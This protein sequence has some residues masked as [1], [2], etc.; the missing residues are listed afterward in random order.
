MSATP[1]ALEL[2]RFQR[3]AYRV[4]ALGCGLLLIGLL[5]DAQQFFRSYLV[6]WLYW[7]APALGSL[8]I[9]MLHKLTGGAWG[10]GIRRLLEAGM[11]TLPL[12]AGLFVPIAFG[13]GSLYEWSHADVVAADP[14]LQHKSVYLNVPFFLA[15]ALGYFAL[16]IWLARTILRL[17]ESYDRNANPRLL[18]RIGRLAGPGLGIYVLTMSFAAFDWGMS[19]E[20]H[21][22]STIY[23]LHFIVGQ[24]LAGLCLAIVVSARL[25][26]REPF[27]RWLGP[28]HF[29][30]LGNLTLAFVMLW[31]YISFSQFLIVWSGNLPE[32][33]PWYIHRLHHGWQAL[34]L[35]LVV[36]HFALPFLVLL[37]RR[38]KR[39]ARLLAR[40]ALVLLALRFVD[41]Y[42]YIAPSFH[43]DGFRLSWMDAAAMVGVGGLWLGTYTR[44]LRGRPLVSLQDARLHASLE[45]VRA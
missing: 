25:S 27:S 23:G 24:A 34:S 3:R 12:L 28:A 22:F 36:F 41:L 20:P 14:L 17:T 43:H 9:V 33:T 44:M 19:L 4:G 15:R 42:W 11:R 38:S 5:V 29:H 40:L 39:N 16:W 10:F 8:A 31:A 45:E 35:L 26:Q 18:R 30:D 37:V 21:W 2:E 13:I 1:I 32:E 7:L 6:A